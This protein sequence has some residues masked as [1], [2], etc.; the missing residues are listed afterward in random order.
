MQYSQDVARNRGSVLLRTTENPE[1]QQEFWDN[2]EPPERISSRRAV[3]HSNTWRQERIYPKRSDGKETPASA[4]AIEKIR[5]PLCNPLRKRRKHWRRKWPSRTERI[6]QAT[7]Q[8]IH[9][10]KAS[11]R[12]YPRCCNANCKNKKPMGRRQLCQRAGINYM[13]GESAST[14]TPRRA[15]LASSRP[16]NNVR[17]SDVTT[18]DWRWTSE[19]PRIE[20]S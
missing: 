4:E 7:V 11:V 2:K 10:W 8:I 9:G 17:P 12:K 5:W 3:R 14:S 16:N 20:L 15:A 19:W 18:G 13:G 6:P 1:N